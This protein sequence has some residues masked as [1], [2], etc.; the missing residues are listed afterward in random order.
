RVS[1]S[2]EAGSRESFRTNGIRV[3]K[4]RNFSKFRYGTKEIVFEPATR[5]DDVYPAPAKPDRESP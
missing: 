5:R 4:G 2:G 3:S 1:C